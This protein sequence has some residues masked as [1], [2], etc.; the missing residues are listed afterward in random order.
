MVTP[1][2]RSRLTRVLL[3]LAWERFYACDVCDKEAPIFIEEALAPLRLKQRESKRLLR[4]LTC[5]CCESPVRAGTFVVPR[6]SGELRRARFARKFEEEYGTLASDFR[7][8]L[9]EHPRLGAEHRFGKLLSKVMKSA[10]TTAVY[11]SIWYRAEPL[12]RKP[13]HDNRYNETGQKAWYLSGDDK[14]AAVEVMR[15]P[16]THTKVR[17]YEIELGEPVEML[18]LRSLVWGEDPI[19]QWILRNLVDNGFLSEPCKDEN[20]TPEYLV[21]QFVADLAR[22]RKIRGIQYDTTRT[23]PQNNPNAGGHNLVI[24]GPRPQ[25]LVRSQSVVEFGEL[26]QLEDDPFCPELW[27]LRIVSTAG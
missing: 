22:A 5:P 17:I 6:D 21:T 27:P 1:R 20:S 4:Q 2:R 3:D 7:E 15:E 10:R 8:F 23:S 25:H 13:P 18:D 11:P 9:I 19:R 14:T 12:D 16:K 26:G 24:F